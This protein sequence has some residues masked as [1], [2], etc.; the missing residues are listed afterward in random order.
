M[1][2]T[3]NPPFP[4]ESTV[5]GEELP[6]PQSIVAVNELAGV[7]ESASVNVATVLVKGTPA[8]AETGTPAAFRDEATVAVVVVVTSP[9]LTESIVTVIV[10]DPVAMYVCVPVTMKPPVPFDE[11]A[12]VE[13]TPSPQSMVA[14][15]WSAVVAESR[16]VRVATVPV[17]ATP[18]LAATPLAT[19]VALW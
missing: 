2:V 16:S 6:S 13:V 10:S 7:V 8:L 1:P 15:N 3:M 9:S 11:T 5:P 19:P 18:A 12:P 4:S 14:L 17:N